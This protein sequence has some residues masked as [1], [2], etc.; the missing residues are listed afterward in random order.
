MQWRQLGSIVTMLII[1]IF[2]FEKFINSLK[3]NETK[4]EN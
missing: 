2:I 4:T 1:I 3:E